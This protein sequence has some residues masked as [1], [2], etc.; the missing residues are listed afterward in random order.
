MSARISTLTTAPAAAKSPN[1]ET[2]RIAGGKTGVLLIHGLCG[3]PAEMRFV[4]L[5]LARAGYTVHCPTLAGHGGSRADIVKSTWQDWYRSAEAALEEL[6]QTCDTVIIGG[7]CLG[8]I[9]ALHL[10]ANNSDKVDGLALFSPTLWTNGWAMPWYSKLFSLV[11]SRWVANLMQFP[12]AESLGIKCPRVR[13]FVRAALAASDGSDL[14]TVGTPGAMV[15]EHRRLVA[16]AKKLLGKIRQPAL[17]V[18]SREDDYA[19]LNNATYLQAKLPSAT[20]LIVLDDSYHMVTLDKQRHV[21][22]ERTRDFVERIATGGN[23]EGTE[24]GGKS[25]PIKAA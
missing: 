10:A 20:D 12:D 5:G 8:G 4:A 7:L 13:E 16:A 6:R 14:G 24:V 19:D 17:I 21:V 15:F 22:V 11:R 23:S 25:R 2:F 9:I 18:H 1:G 3:T